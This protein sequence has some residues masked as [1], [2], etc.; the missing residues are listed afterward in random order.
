M[1]ASDKIA[2]FEGIALANGRRGTSEDVRIGPDQAAEMLETMKYPYQRKISKPH[3]QMLAQ[4]MLHGRF[5]GSTQIRLASFQGRKYLIDGQHRLSAV[6]QS[7]TSQWFSV[8]SEDAPSPEYIAWQYGVTDSNK[9]RKF[10]DLTSTLNLPERLDMT[11]KHI[12]YLAAAVD[13]LMGGMDRSGHKV[14]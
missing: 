3:V 13:I 14:N 12:R 7:G 8:V 11:S 9:V 10:L 4:E 5:T 2:H 1:T 6:V